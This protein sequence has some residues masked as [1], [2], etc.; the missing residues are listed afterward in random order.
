MD[1]L[2][3]LPG[4][5]APSARVPAH[6]PVHLN[7]QTLALRALHATVELRLLKAQRDVVSAFSYSGVLVLY[8]Q[9][10]G[11]SSFVWYFVQFA[12]FWPSCRIEEAA[13]AAPPPEQEKHPMKRYTSR[14]DLFHVLS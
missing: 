2:C 4:V 7:H 9:K 1:Y 3:S 6:H 10:V 13:E 5:A 12:R 8:V 14:S 11:F